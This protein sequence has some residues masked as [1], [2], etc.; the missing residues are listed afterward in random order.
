MQ[1]TDPPLYASLPHWS[2]D[3]TQILFS[4]TDKT[5]QVKGYIIPSQGGPPRLILPEDQEGQVDPNWSPDGRKIVFDTRGISDA[6][7]VAI[8]ILDLT[9][10]QVNRSRISWQ[11]LPALV[12]QR[13]IHRRNL[14]KPARPGSLRIRDRTMVSAAEG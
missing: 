7:G 3:G 12:S 2:P 8:R 6:K 11:V 13:P 10:H 14:A 1:L 9:S 4:A 5:G